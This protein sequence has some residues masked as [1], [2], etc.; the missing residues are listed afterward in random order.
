MNLSEYLP[1]K[2]TK[3]RKKR[4]RKAHRSHIPHRVSIRE[5]PVSIE[6]RVEFGHWEGDTVEGKGHRDGIHTE[7]ERTSRYLLAAKVGRITS[8]ETIKVQKALFGALPEQARKSTTLDN[9][10]ENH[11]HF[12]LVEVGM[13]T[14]LPIPTRPGSEARTRITTAYSGGTC[15]R[16]RRSTI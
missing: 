10:R 2:R 3:R 5:R 15:R 7:V 16:G 1:R 9:G 8:E 4:G 14:Y 6:E 11:H 12:Q 13:A